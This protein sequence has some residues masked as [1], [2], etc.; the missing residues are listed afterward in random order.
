M[1]A[2]SALLGGLGLSLA[3]NG[4]RCIFCLV[5]GS[6]SFYNQRSGYCCLFAVKFLFIMSVVMPVQ[7]CWIGF[8]VVVSSCSLSFGC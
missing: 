1:C 6:R 2:Y 7:S 5:N 8:I 4:L 3:K